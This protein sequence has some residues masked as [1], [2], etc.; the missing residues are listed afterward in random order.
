MNNIITY[1]YELKLEDLKDLKI[2]WLDN[3]LF[4]EFNTIYVDNFDFLFKINLIILEGVYSFQLN[5]FYEKYREEYKLHKI[6]IGKDI[7]EYL[8]NLNIK[9]YKN[10]VEEK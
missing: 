4:A 7:K 5:G 6:S 8:E 2:S 3:K 10:Q 9:H 1:D